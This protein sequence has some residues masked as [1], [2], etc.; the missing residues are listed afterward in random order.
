MDNSFFVFPPNVQPFI[1]SHTLA[2]CDAPGNLASG[3][4]PSYQ[5][6]PWTEQFWGEDS[7]G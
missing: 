6:L 4:L 1:I 5:K 7:S 2:D 3:L